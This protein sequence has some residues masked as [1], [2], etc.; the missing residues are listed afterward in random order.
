M[1]P[2]RIVEETATHVTYEYRTAYTWLLYAAAAVFV[3]GMASSIYAIEIAGMIMVV[4]Y[5]V[6]KVLL[7]MKVNEKIRQA[8]ASNAIQLSGSRSSFSNPLR[9]RI[10]K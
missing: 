3:A 9:I 2:Y 8:M 7:G 4:L 5:F 6:A 10:P 1:N